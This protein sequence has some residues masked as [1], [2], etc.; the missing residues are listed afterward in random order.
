MGWMC[1][2]EGEWRERKH[3][4][5]H[6]PSVAS[7]GA[8]PRGVPLLW[9]QQVQE[10]LFQP[11]LLLL[12]A[13]GWEAPLLGFQGPGP[14]RREGNTA[15]W[16]GRGLAC[17]LKGCSLDPLQRVWQI[18]RGY[19]YNT[20]FCRLLPFYPFSFFK[21]CKVHVKFVILAILKCLRYIHS[22]V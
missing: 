8:P 2:R 17:E 22:V 14:V 9:G 21:N 12:Q 11:G 7:R 16:A 1:A 3:R 10:P 6:G 20:D 4:P 19:W 18:L 13:T 15:P 5:T